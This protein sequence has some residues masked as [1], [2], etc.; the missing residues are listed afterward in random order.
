MASYNKLATLMGRHQEL[1]S[2]RRFRRLNAKSLLYMQAEIL[3]LESELGAI[4]G[5]DQRSG[6]KVRSSLHTSVFN[7]KESCGS[8]HDVQWKKVLNI[9]DKLER[10]SKSSKET[11][12]FDINHSKR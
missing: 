7:L 2:F 6:D 5:E 8:P 9:R 10:Y 3:H 11:S 1:A 4:E 12:S